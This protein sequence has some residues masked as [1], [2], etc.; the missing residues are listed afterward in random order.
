[1]AKKNEYDKIHHYSFKMSNNDLKIWQNHF[2]LKPFHMVD[3]KFDLVLWTISHRNPAMP[4]IFVLK[5]FLR[6]I[7]EMKL[8][9]DFLNLNKTFFWL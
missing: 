6:R 1:M 4:F 8:K 9:N 3:A 5:V 7:E 2:L